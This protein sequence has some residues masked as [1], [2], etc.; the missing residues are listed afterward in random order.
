MDRTFLKEKVIKLRKRGK[1]YSEIQKNLRVTI[2]EST[3][4]YWCRDVELPKEYQERIKKIILRNAEKGRAIAVVANRVK[5]EKYL[6][7]LANRNR[8]LTLLLKNRDV[9]KIALAMLY[10]GEGGK[11]KSHRGLLLGS[12][13]PEIISIYI[14][15]LQ[16]CYNIGSE[17]MRAR[18]LFR[19]DQ[20]LNSL[21]MFWSRVTGIP[22][23]HFYKTKPD[24]R[25]IGKKTKKKDYRG[26][27]VITCGG[28][29]I[30]LEL[31]IIAKMFLKK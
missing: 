18:I 25:T 9:A 12:S 28:T 16:K 23:H 30:Q 5:R 2:P 7:S 8:N 1:I 3:L 27:C 4:S 31:D 21:L 6:K 17:K 26:V 10:L 13:D 11:W 20:N 24:A 19:A 14:K 15:L 22:K 29:E